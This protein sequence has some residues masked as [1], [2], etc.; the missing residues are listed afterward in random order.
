[1]ELIKLHSITTDFQIRGIFLCVWKS[2]LFMGLG[3]IIVVVGCDYE[4]DLDQPPS[5]P[6]WSPL[7]LGIDTLYFLPVDS[8][9]TTVTIIVSDQDGNVMQGVK[10][11]VSL[12]NPELG[13]LEFLDTDLRDTTNAQGRVDLLFTAIG[14]VGDMVFTATAG[15]IVQ[16]RA[17][18][19]R[20][21]ELLAVSLQITM[22]PDSIVAAQ[23]DT[24]STEICVLVM[25]PDGNG[26]EGI[27][28]PISTQGGRLQPLP[29]TNNSGR[30][31]TDWILEATQGDHCLF[32][33]I[34]EIADSA[35]VHIDIADSIQSNNLL[36]P[37]VN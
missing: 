13:Y 4:S 3:I 28:I 17:L 26:I 24:V 15:D 20:E 8:A 2:F 11:N 23:G 31:C 6:W 27:S 29:A 19:I 37:I 10:V 30:A 22:T 9:S 34:G 18:A 33:S 7:S 1:M 5:P 21:F 25:D 36:T 16:T 14:T 35:C 12:D 32:L